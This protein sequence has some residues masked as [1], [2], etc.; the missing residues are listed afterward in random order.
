MLRHRLVTSGLSLKFLSSPL[1]GDKI[2]ASCHGLHS[3]FFKKKTTIG[4]LPLCPGPP[5]VP[6][7]AYCPPAICIAPGCPFHRM[8]PHPRLAPSGFTTSVEPSGPCS[9]Y[10]PAWW[11]PP[12]S[13]LSGFPPHPFNCA[14]IKLITPCENTVL[15]S[16]FHQLRAPW[17][18]GMGASISDPP[19]AQYHV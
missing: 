9:F 4:L 14:A 13:S 18:R 12:T 17:Q 19:N 2:Q 10:S 1:P 7:P 16:H 3:P 15:V 11:S 5:P 6:L 8:H